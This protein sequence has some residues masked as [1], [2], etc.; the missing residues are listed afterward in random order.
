LVQVN[1]IVVDVRDVRT[2]FVGG[3]RLDVLAYRDDEYGDWVP[4]DAMAATLNTYALPRVRPVMFAEET[5]PTVT[6][7]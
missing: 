4:F 3:R 1:V 6:Y 5:F 2:K 7:L